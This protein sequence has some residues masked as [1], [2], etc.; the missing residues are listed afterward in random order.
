MFAFGSL[1]QH[2][3]SWQGLMN[4]ILSFY[5][6]RLSGG[7]TQRCP[8]GCSCLLVPLLIPFGACSCLVLRGSGDTKTLFLH[9]YLFA[10][11]MAR[12]EG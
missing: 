5:E 7:D 6:Y 11:G 12:H 10:K 4:G 9:A 8:C 2:F 1:P 3:G